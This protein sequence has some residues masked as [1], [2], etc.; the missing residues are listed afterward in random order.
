MVYEYSAAIPIVRSCNVSRFHHD[1]LCSSMKNSHLWRAARRSTAGRRDRRAVVGAVWT[2]RFSPAVRLANGFFFVF[3]FSF[4]PCS[5]RRVIADQPLSCCRRSASAFF[6]L[7]IAKLTCFAVRCPLSG[8]IQRISRTVFFFR[9]WHISRATSFGPR[10]GRVLV[11]DSRW[12]LSIACCFFFYCQIACGVVVVYQRRGLDGRQHPVWSAAAGVA[13]SFPRRLS[14]GKLCR[15]LL[16]SII[17]YQ[18]SFRYYTWF[19]L[20]VIHRIS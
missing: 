1:R 11:A 9:S 20:D 18:R 3:L 17:C 5:G 15:D 4:G 14:P 2:S 13:S 12:V 7:F 10:S 19:Y 8:Y 16:L 6:G